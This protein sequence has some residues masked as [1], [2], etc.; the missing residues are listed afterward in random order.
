MDSAP[1]S[2]PLTLS[3]VIPVFN[4]EKTIEQ[5]LDLIEK[6]E[7]PSITKEIIIINDASTDTTEHIL[8]AFNG[9]YK[10][11]HHPTNGGKGASLKAGFNI[12]HGDFVI[13]QDADLE[14]E[15]NDY[16]R[17]IPPLIN[18]TADV[19]YGTRLAGDRPYRNHTSLHYYANVFL[20]FL[21]N[22]CNGLHLTDVETCYKIFTRKALDSFKD[23]LVS[24]RFGIDLEL[25]A[26]VAKKKL[27]VVEIPIAY[28]SRTHRE[29]KKIG[30][31]DGVAAI[32]HILY[33][34]LIA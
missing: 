4:E 22:L 25:T 12:A 26:Q 24:N 20:T 27:R 23:E 1:I 30:W 9:K 8:K 10:V 28:T 3:I 21:S 11:I 16:A 29:G 2:R 34:N 18:G 32:Y 15:P 7:L 17:L 6:V 33:F 31:K 13:I 19:V 14:Y 5:L